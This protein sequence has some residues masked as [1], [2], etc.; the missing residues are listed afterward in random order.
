M[1]KRKIGEKEK[2]MLLISDYFTQSPLIIH[3]YAA[4]K[5][6]LKRKIKKSAIVF[7][8]TNPSKTPF[9]GENQRREQDKGENIASSSSLSLSPCKTIFLD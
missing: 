1:R 4:L 5:V 3:S 9:F 7:L 2:V 8:S 6:Q